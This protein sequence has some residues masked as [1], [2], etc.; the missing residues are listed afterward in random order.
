M[1]TSII[2]L[3]PNIKLKIQRDDNMKMMITTR[4]KALDGCYPNGWR[5]LSLRLGGENI[6]I[7][8]TICLYDHDIIL[9]NSITMPPA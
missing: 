9:N 4:W 3:S 2:G 7:S 6:I 1:F 5:Y 8:G